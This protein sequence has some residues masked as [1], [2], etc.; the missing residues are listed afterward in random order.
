MQMKQDSLGKRRLLMFIYSMGSGGAE[1]VTANL[2]N[3]WA[4]KG[5]DITIVTQ[6]PQS[7]DFYELHPAV[8]RVVL[9]LGGESD[10]V[11]IGLRQ[12]V[13][14]V[15]MLRKLLCVIKPDIALGMMAT[16]NVVLALAA[17]GLPTIRTI[18][19]E[20]NHPPQK[21]LGIVWENLRRHTY[22]LLNAVT[23]LAS[24]GESWLKRNTNAKR[25]SVIPNAVTWPLPEREPRINPSIYH[26]P[27][28][29]LLLAVGRLHPQKGFDWLIEIFSNIAPKYPNWDLVI[30]GEGYLHGALEKQIS[31]YNLEK[32]VFLPGPVGNLREWYECA[33]IYVMSSRYEGFGNTLVEAIAHGLPVI[34]FDCD[35]GPRNIIRDHINGFLV[36]PNDLGALTAALDTLMG[37][38]ALRLQLAKSAVDVQKR[39][40]MEKIANLWEKLFDSVLNTQSGTR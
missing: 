12:N 39:F 26:P 9:N 21:P 27:E 7:L 4:G 24:E 1:R 36:P 38:K 25:V 29:Q 16:A 37:D 2:G 17:W 11:L 5:W 30:L 23:A 28:R 8:K 33:D 6:T 18:G 3:Y 35:T 20:H 31:G 32:R 10:N 34:S 22:G 40:S 15:V 19:V 14:R 13:L